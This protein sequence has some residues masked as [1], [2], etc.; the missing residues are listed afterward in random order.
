ML[1]YYLENRKSQSAKVISIKKLPDYYHTRCMLPITESREDAIKS[2]I[3]PDANNFDQLDTLRRKELFVFQHLGESASV[4]NLCIEKTWYTKW[5][6]YL[7][8]AKY[9]GIVKTSEL[10]N[11]HGKLKNEIFEDQDYVVLNREQYDYLKNIYC[12]EEEVEKPFIPQHRRTKS[13][14]NQQLKSFSMNTIESNIEAD[15]QK[16]EVVTLMDENISPQSEFKLSETDTI[17]AMSV[18]IMK[19]KFGL[20]NPGFFCY[21]NA[22]IQCLLTIQPIVNHFV[23]LQTQPHP[24]KQPYTSHIFSLI[25]KISQD[26]K[27]ILRPTDLWKEVNKYF[28]AASQHDFNEFFRFLLSRL[29]QEALTKPSIYEKIFKGIMKSTIKCSSCNHTSSHNEEIWDIAA[30][31]SIS[32]KRSLKIFTKSEEIDFF[33]EKCKKNSSA[34]K[35]LQFLNTPEV[36]IIQLKRFKAEQKAY[37]INDH[38]KFHKH[39]N[40]ETVS[41]KEKY[42]L[43]CIAEHK[44][45]INYGHYNAYCKRSSKWYKFNDTKFE[46]ISLAKVLNKKM[47]CAVYCKT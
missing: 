5:I 23:T 24:R 32:L 40:V 2:P 42:Q 25:C 27:R 21:L 14:N 41:G 15:Q 39:L 36:L 7:N 28:S 43:L 20:E 12:S 44:G 4:K 1:S 10:R 38:C 22:V 45:S 34:S 6:A 16:Y 19:R 9:P 29:N 35:Q 8:G 46:K 18:R 11:K 26:D 33:C 3:D 17:P 30:E 47:Y 13:N 37:K 31:F